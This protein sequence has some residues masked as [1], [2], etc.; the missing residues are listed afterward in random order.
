MNGVQYLFGSV[1]HC[2]C[3]TGK[4]LRLTYIYN[5]LIGGVEFEYEYTIV[6]SG[7]QYLNKAQLMTY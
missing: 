3:L 1:R 5:S 7:K 6:P 4:A 2:A